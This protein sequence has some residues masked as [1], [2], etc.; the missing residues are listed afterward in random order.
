MISH[1]N[2]TIET[3]NRVL[4]VDATGPFNEA[5]IN[6]YQLALISSV[7]ALSP[8][9]WVML[10][11]LHDESLFTP[12]AESRLTEVIKWRKAMGMNR[13]GLLFVNTVATHILQSQMSRMYDQA[14]VEHAFFD[15]LEDARHWVQETACTT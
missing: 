10:V 14:G 6:E 11:T 13:V 2:Y 12:D 4:A 8:E 15:N 9:P 5:L 7:E 1:G 3:E